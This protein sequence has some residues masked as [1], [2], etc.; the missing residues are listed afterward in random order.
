MNSNSKGKRKVVQFNTHFSE[1]ETFHT[2]IHGQQSALN[3]G[4][5]YINGRGTPLKTGNL[6]LCSLTL[7]ILKAQ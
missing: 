5:H 3:F 4:Y 6:K 2:L 1:S 7:T